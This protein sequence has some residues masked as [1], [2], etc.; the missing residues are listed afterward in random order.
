MRGISITV[1][2]GFP[3]G[4]IEELGDTFVAAV[5]ALDDRLMNLSVEYVLNCSGSRQCNPN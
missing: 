3:L 2:R 1:D 5:N 4:F